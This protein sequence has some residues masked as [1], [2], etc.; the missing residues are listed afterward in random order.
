MLRS[1]IVAAAVIGCMASVGQ[2][3]FIGTVDFEDGTVGPLTKVINVSNPQSFTI[4]DFGGPGALEFNH[5]GVGT[6]NFKSSYRLADTSG[7]GA[8]DVYG[9]IAMGA[10]FKPSNEFEIALAARVQDNGSAFGLQASN[11]LGGVRIGYQNTAG[12]TSGKGTTAAAWENSDPISLD[13]AKWYNLS[14][15]AIGSTAT[16]TVSELD[17]SFLPVA[18]H[19]VT[20]S[21]TD[22]LG[23]M[24][25]TGYA[26]TRGAQVNNSLGYT[27][28]NITFGEIPEPAGLGL[29]GVAVLGLARRRRAS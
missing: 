20:V 26:G 12:G 24:F 15:S 17:A 22:T 7:T 27:L 2:A 14:F 1:T 21:Y 19:S 5:H 6:G 29:L 4:G 13:P 28:D 10:L 23:E 8:G 25:A 3:A 11:G 16:G 9:D 18:G